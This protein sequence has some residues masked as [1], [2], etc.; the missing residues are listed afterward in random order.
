MRIYIFLSVCLQCAT[1]LFQ[2]AFNLSVARNT[3]KRV[4]RCGRLLHT[5]YYG[6]SNYTV[7]VMQDRTRLNEKGGKLR[8]CIS[9]KRSAFPKANY[10]QTV[11][12]SRN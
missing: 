4:I 8:Q 5:R 12:D 9:A 7:V 10:D 1:Y 11:C 3:T 6:A 2:R